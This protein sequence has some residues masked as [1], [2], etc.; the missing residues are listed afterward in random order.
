MDKINKAAAVG[1]VFFSVMLAGFVGMKVDQ[2]TIALLG[3]AFI[4]LVVA[5]PTTVIIVVLGLRD[6]GAAATPVQQQPAQPQFWNAPPAQS[7]QIPLMTTVNH[8]HDHKYVVV[9][10]VPEGT[11][12]QDKRFIVA[13]ELR[14]LPTQA[15]RM[16]DAGE[17]KLLPAGRQ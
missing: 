5:I 15:Q 1:V 10:H 13:R 4:G 14:V 6:A 16:I 11:P 8:Y 2:T 17:V 3:G 7:E 12:D 9:V